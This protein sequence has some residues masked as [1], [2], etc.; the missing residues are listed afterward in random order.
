MGSHEIPA[1]EV[2]Y[3]TETWHSCQQS[4][5]IIPSNISG[6]R[7]VV[8]VHC[9]KEGNENAAYISLLFDIMISYRG[10]KL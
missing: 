8:C 6:K 9:G 5:I 3:E 10:L 2:S 7:I 1:V 4:S